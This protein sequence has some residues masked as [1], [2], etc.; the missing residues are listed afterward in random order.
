MLTIHIV[1]EL[2]LRSH[3]ET[4]IKWREPTILKIVLTYNTLCDQ[5]HALIRQCKGPTGAIPPQHISH[6]GIFQL[7]IDDDMAF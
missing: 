1:I 2:N 5:L 4:S 6:D 7:D 3:T